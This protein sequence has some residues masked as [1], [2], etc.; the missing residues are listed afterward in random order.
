MTFTGL[1]VP[2]TLTVRVKSAGTKVAV[3]V[4]FWFMT[5][6]S[7]GT[8]GTEPGG[9]SPLHPVNTLLESGM[10]VRVTAVEMGRS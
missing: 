8:S 2:A 3:M 10:A 7:T 5:T 9:R 6:L 4:R 1:A